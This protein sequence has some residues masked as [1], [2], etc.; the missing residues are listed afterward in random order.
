MSTSFEN[1]IEK[2][3]MEMDMQMVMPKFKAPQKRVVDLYDKDDVKPHLRR[4]MEHCM[5]KNVNP[6]LPVV[7]DWLY[8]DKAFDERDDFVKIERLIEMV[9]EGQMYPMLTLEVLEYA[10][11]VED[12]AIKV[13]D[14]HD[15]NKS[16]DEAVE[17]L[18]KTLEIRLEK[19]KE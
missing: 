8:S 19:R 6:E 3:N 12:A 2:G 1:Y 16:I 10:K 11:K 4:F 14:S 5:A 9:K 18:R 15:E 13:I 7:L 17:N